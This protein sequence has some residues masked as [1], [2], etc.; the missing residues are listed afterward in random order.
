[1]DGVWRFAIVVV[2]AYFAA[3]VAAD[4]ITLVSGEKLHGT[5]LEQ[6][7]EV[8]R[9][10]HPVLGELTIPRAGVSAIGVPP[11]SPADAPPPT[12]APPVDAPPVEP[13]AEPPPPPMPG[14]LGTT[15]LQGW[16]RQ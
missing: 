12:T 1:M 15:F 11:A 13:A 14:L 2:L 16:D 5:L 4:E 7:D 10:E 3:R 8:V 9:F 6:T